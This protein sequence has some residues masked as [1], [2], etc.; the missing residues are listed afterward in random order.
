VLRHLLTTILSFPSFFLF[1]S[2]PF[3]VFQEDFSD[4]EEEEEYHPEPAVATASS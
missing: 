4:E 1:P 2:F 3:L